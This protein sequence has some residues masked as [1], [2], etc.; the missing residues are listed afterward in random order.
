MIFAAQLRAKAI[1]LA[2]SRH[3]TCRSGPVEVA[4]GS[5]LKLEGD[6]YAELARKVEAAVR[7]L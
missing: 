2:A 7:A 3:R 5:P 4:F 1:N 6:D